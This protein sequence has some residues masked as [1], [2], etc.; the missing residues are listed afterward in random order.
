[1]IRAVLYPFILDWFLSFPHFCC[2]FLCVNLLDFYS[3]GEGRAIKSERSITRW[4]LVS[5][6]R[7]IMRLFRFDSLLFQWLTATFVF[8][9][10]FCFVFNVISRSGLSLSV[11]LSLSLSSAEIA[12]EH[13]P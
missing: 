1:M 13:C 2:F 4:R 8:M 3:G 6:N 12:G 11:S 9:L 5:F 10:L 7:C